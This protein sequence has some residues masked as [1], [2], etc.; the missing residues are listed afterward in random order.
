LP[1]LDE[2][3]TGDPCRADPEILVARFQVSGIRS[4][5]TIKLMLEPEVDSL[6]IP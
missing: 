4:Q 6:V 5:E 2:A 1:C 3:V